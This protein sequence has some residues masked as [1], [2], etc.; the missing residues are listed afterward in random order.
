MAGD[1]SDKPSTRG[2]QIF[3]QFHGRKRGG[4]TSGPVA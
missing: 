1:N 2:D 4:R 3:R